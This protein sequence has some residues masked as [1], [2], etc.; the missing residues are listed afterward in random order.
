[1]GELRDEKLNHWILFGRDAGQKWM[2]KGH[3]KNSYRGTTDSVI[4]F[5]IKRWDANELTRRK[6]IGFLGI[7]EY[8]IKEKAILIE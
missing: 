6:Q 3:K 4:I 5:D 1:M 7:R 8:D 2:Y